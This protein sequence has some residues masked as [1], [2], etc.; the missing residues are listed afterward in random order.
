MAAPNIEPIVRENWIE[1]VAMPREERGTEFCIATT[2]VWNIC[3]MPDP[4]STMQAIACA[5]EEWTLNPLSIAKPTRVVIE[6]EIGQIR[7]RPV[8]VTV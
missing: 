3:P 4:I 6:P 2:Y 1:A 5:R 7:Y 8:R